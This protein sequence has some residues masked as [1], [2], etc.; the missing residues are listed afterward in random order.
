MRRTYMG[1]GGDKVISEPKSE[2]IMGCWEKKKLRNEY[3]RNLHSAKN[4]MTKIKSKRFR[5]ARGSVVGWDSMLQVGRSWV[6]VPMKWIFFDL[7][8]PSSRNMALGSTQPLTEM[9]TSNLHRG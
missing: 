8:N 1:G 7:P 3:P 5:W 2:E 4:I 6:R 9:S